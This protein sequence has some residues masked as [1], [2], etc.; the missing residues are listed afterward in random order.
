M[1]CGSIETILIVAN[2]IQGFFKNKEAKQK[3]KGAALIERLDQVKKWKDGNKKTIYIVGDEYDK[4]T[5]AFTRMA[6]FNKGK[7]HQG[8]SLFSQALNTLVRRV[9]VFVE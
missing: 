9:E 6:R 4:L 7:P 2:V 5:R 1:F 8:L 3:L